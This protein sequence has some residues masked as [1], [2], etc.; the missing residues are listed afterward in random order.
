MRNNFFIGDKVI[1]GVVLVLSLA[2]ILFVY[3][4]SSNLVFVVKEGTTWLHL[5]KQIMI[6]IMGV[7]VMFF[8]AK[9]KLFYVKKFSFVALSLS[10]GMLIYAFFRGTVIE[11][12]VAS[13]WIKV[14]FLSIQP[15]MFAYLSLVVYLSAR[16]SKNNL[17]LLGRYIS[18]QFSD[19]TI[20]RLGIVES[21]FIPIVAVVVLVAKDNGST[22]GMILITSI[23]ILF[24][25]QM[26][27]KYIV[28]FL[29]T[30]IVLGLISYAVLR[31]TD[32]GEK[33]SRINTWMSRIENYTSKDKSKKDKKDS[34]Y[35]INRAKAAIIHGGLWG[36][37]PGKSALK[38]ILPQ[39][40]SDFIF[41]I[42]VEEYG[43]F[44]ALLII[45]FYFSIVIRTFLIAIN[46]VDPFKS[47]LT[48]SIGFMFFL[49][50]AM[51]IAVTLAIIPVTGQPLPFFSYGGTA[52]IVIYIELGLILNISATTK[53][54]I[55]K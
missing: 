26:K 55:K 28:Y 44:S 12:A 48:V 34:D 40:A 3:S 50:Q 29:G 32:F 35:Q 31:T 22:A 51:N 33:N 53:E 27:F 30:C 9:L 21:I 41:A 14:G 8:T 23:A 52:M 54:L 19:R 16:L 4:A 24:F 1:W 45:L 36:V 13:R 42:I 39:S 6:V 10:I 25:G 11:G 37:G 38:Q 2:S 5:V 46:V 7:A 49:Q 47:L 43:L 18:S 15:S 20:P 17:P